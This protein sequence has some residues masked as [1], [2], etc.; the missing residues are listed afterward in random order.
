MRIGIRN[1]FSKPV[2]GTADA[3]RTTF[4]NMCIKHRCLDI[5]V[6]QKFLDR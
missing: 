1:Y 3:S 2:H 6:P 4:E 5:F